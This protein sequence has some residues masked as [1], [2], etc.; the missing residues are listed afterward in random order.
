MRIC[1]R[2]LSQ[3]IEWYQTV[4]D[5]GLS[6]HCSYIYYR[7]CNTSQFQLIRWL[8]EINSISAIITCCIDMSS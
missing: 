8:I 7:A 6:D 5:R 4:Y 3:G 2:H 1:G